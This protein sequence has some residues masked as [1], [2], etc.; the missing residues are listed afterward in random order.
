VTVDDA[1]RRL[2]GVATRAQLLRACSRHALHKALASG[3]VVRSSRNRYTLP[4]TDAARATAH[5]LSGALCLTS[6]ALVH[7]WAVKQ[8]PDRPQVAVAR[9]RRVAPGTP[10][11]VKRFRLGTD[12]VREGVTTPDRTLL[13]CLRE[14][15]FDE[16]LAIADSAL[17]SGYRRARMLALVR[18]ARGPKAARMRAI[19]AL[20]TDKAANPFESVLRAIALGVGGLSVRPQVSLHRRDGSIV[21]GG[22]FLGRP[23]LVDEVLRIV[24]EADSFEWHGDRAALRRD[25]QRY[26][27]FVVAG[28][29][30][31]R[32]SWEDVMF[33]P[34]LVREVLVAAVL[35]RT[36]QLCPACRAAS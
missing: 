25:A 28:W 14:L 36:N 13:D 3:E 21:G 17:R 19:A 1:L 20:A 34:D 18:D 4:E 22:R 31:L 33:D 16:A 32:F 35:E 27:A 8:P 5:A 30:V 11:E 7:G 2:G 23:D 6:A 9:G 12:D 10:A 29:L 24:I 15:P 26:N